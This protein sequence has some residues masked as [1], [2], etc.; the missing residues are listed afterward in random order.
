MLGGTVTRSY[1]DFSQF[2]E[3][4]RDAQQLPGR[5]IEQVAKQF[6][7]IFVNMV[8]KSMRDA[9]FG[10]PLFDSNQ[11]EFYQDMFDKQISL[12]MS[13][14]KG[15]GLASTLI[16]QMQ[17]YVP[18]EKNEQMT[19]K[20]ATSDPFILEREQTQFNTHEEFVSTIQPYA[21]QAAQSLGLDPAVL[22]AQS[23]LETGW[24]KSVGKLA[25]G[26]SSYNLFN[27][28]AGKNYTGKQFSRKTVEYSDGI[29]KIDKASFRAYNS[30]QESF[31]DYVRLI[32]NSPRYQEALNVSSDSKR[33]L[34]GLQKAGYATDPHYSEKINRVLESIS[35]RDDNVNFDEDYV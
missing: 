7:S 22:I 25:N 4:R 23:A 2:T 8:L 20:T 27:I 18:A 16:Q 28:K 32:R 15:I 6:E 33:Y 1:T 30:Y 17:K 12:E 14:G 11:S 13:N 9:S 10:D 3:M 19:A 29:A 35:V 5:S 24:G 31:D 21:E 34:D 26:D